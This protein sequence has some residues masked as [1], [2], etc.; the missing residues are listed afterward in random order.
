MLLLNEYVYS[1]IGNRAGGGTRY[2]CPNVNKGCKARAIVLD[3][4]VILAA[5]NEHNH[6]PLKY[7]KTNNGLYFRL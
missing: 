7:L 4:G 5:N 6:E 2:R 3:D 1:K